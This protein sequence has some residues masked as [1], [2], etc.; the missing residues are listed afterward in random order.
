MNTDEILAALNA[1]EGSNIWEDLI[2]SIPGYDD[3]ATEIID[4]ACY[5]NIFVLED[6]STF[7]R[8]QGE[9]IASW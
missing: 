5:N 6:N 3:L 9:W 8:E 4:P 2:R 7:V 1:Y